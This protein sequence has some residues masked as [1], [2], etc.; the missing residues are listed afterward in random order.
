MRTIVVVG[1]KLQGVEACYLAKKAGI[2]T[3]LLDKNPKA[4]A[5]LMADEFYQIDI[6][7]S[8][9]NI[10]D[11]MKKGDFILPALENDEV[12]NCLERL[13]QE[14]GL[15]IAF[16]FDAYRISSSKLLSDRL[17][18]SLQIPAPVYYPE[19]KPP[20]VIKPNKASG[21]VGVRLINTEEE[22]KNMLNQLDRDYEPVIQEFLEGD[23]YSIEV[24]G[25]TGNYRTYE[26]TQ[27]HIDSHYDCCRVT[28]PCALT[29]SIKEEMR[30]IAVRLA[31]AVKLNGIMDVEVI[32]S[33]GIPKV[34]EIDARIP[35]QTPTV[36]YQSTGINF[37][38]ELWHLFCVGRLPDQEMIPTR[39][40]VY[41]HLW[42]KDGAIKEVGEHYMSIRKPLSY[43]IDFMNSDE[44]ITDFSPGD[45]EL[46][47]TFIN[48]GKT[49]T[50]INQKRLR[51]YDILKKK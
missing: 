18:S 42:V 25:C 46:T 26:I 50:E 2:R 13:G 3:I 37:I 8:D 40:S 48:T 47:G 32:L 30:K 31:Q 33:N 22:L 44:V 11:I 10:K 23:S 6:L 5:S 20:Y 36:V 24:I 17:F 15:N 39:Y 27:I 14:E 38:D 9:I 35:S 43:C 51:L 16:D 34:L 4:L 29:N 45:N 21:S 28:S 41:E 49:L 1:G 12:L 19:A 7:S